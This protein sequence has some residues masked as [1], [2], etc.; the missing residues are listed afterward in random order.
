MWYST[1]DVVAVLLYR[2]RRGLYLTPTYT[3]LG[4]LGTVVMDEI[5]G[6]EMDDDDDG[7]KTI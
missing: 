5:D 4:C 2:N 1:D 3:W 7:V 6:M